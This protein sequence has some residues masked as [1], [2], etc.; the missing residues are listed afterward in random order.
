MCAWQTTSYWGGTRKR[1]SKHE[2]A[3]VSMADA[4]KPNAEYY[5]RQQARRMLDMNFRDIRRAA[6]ALAGDPLDAS[7]QPQA[8]PQLSALYTAYP[9]ALGS[10]AA[11]GHTGFLEYR[12]RVD[13]ATV[14]LLMD[15]YLAGEE[16]WKGTEKLDQDIYRKMAGIVAAK[17]HTRVLLEELSRYNELAAIEYY[18]LFLASQQELRFRSVPRILDSLLLFGDVLPDWHTMDLHPMTRSLLED[19]SEA[20]SPYE[21]RVGETKSAGLNDLGLEWSIA[22]LRS[23]HP[24]LPE[25]PQ[26]KP[27]QEE[28]SPFPPDINPALRRHLELERM[29]RRFGNPKDAPDQRTPDGV[30]PMDG[31]APPS[32]F[33]PESPEQQ[34]ADAIA[35]TDPDAPQDKP[36]APDSGQGLDEQVRKDIGEFQAAIGQ[37]GNQTSNWEDMRSDK[38]EAAVR[39]AGFD[40]GPMEG[41]PAEGHEVEVPVGDAEGGGEIF[42]RAVEL[43]ED[44]QACDKLRRQAEPVAKQLRKNLYPN[45]EQVPET[46]RFQSSGPSFDP[47]RLALAGVS[48][49]VYKRYRVHER[50]DRRGRPVLLIACDGSGSLSHDQMQMTKLLGAGWL[51]STARTRIQVM[52]GLYHSGH[53]RPG[54]SHPLVQ[55]MYHPEKTPTTS[56]NEAVRALPTLPETGTGVQSDA[57]SIRFMV[58]EARRVGRNSTIYLILISDTA[59]NECLHLGKSGHEEVTACLKSLQEELDDRFHVTLVAVGQRGVKGFDQVVDKVI[60]V[61]AGGLG[62]PAKVAQ[63]IGSYVATCIRER[64]KLVT[65]R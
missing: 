38:V 20:C 57:L 5:V 50:A 6:A 19:L 12:S 23:L 41:S 28:E 39:A 29:R 8:A 3:G 65:R 58:D 52:A 49:A 9:P 14:P 35:Q 15:R 45:R 61:P 55:W 24:Y 2:W 25:R 1:R 56:R 34:L 59:W 42:D 27:E 31:K 7:Y 4:N 18:R 64:Q 22:V 51:L 53:V 62:D 47:A 10:Y 40:A 48:D 30:P 13:Q 54:Q 44:T 60:S 33:D 37:A 46:E 63:E 36:A 16:A 11:I 43:S 26:G 21:L 32:L 17:L